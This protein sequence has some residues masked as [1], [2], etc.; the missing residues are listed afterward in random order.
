MPI[1]DIA[2]AESRFPNTV[3]DPPMGDTVQQALR[4]SDLDPVLSTAR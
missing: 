4:E 2:F 3:V 1:A